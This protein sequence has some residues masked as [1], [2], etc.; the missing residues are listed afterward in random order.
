MAG[1]RGEG[2]L[3]FDSPSCTV[4]S[5][6]FDKCESSDSAI[7]RTMSYN[8]LLRQNLDSKNRAILVKPLTNIYLIRLTVELANKDGGIVNRDFMHR[9]SRSRGRRTIEI[10]CPFHRISLGIAESLPSI[11]RWARLTGKMVEVGTWYALMAS[12]RKTKRAKHPVRHS[13][14]ARFQV[15]GITISSTCP[16]GSRSAFTAYAVI[17]A[18]SH[19]H[20]WGRGLQLHRHVLFLWR[21]TMSC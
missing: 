16:N 8:V 21:R 2:Y 18:N 19:P 14:L 10:L 5:I 4:P 17:S 9:R 12:S 15:L 20:M 6:I 13:L 1:E 11:F 3:R 7:R